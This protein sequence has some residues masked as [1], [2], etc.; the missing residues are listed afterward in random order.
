MKFSER[1]WEVFYGENNSWW[2]KIDTI[3]IPFLIIISVVVM[4]LE[5]TA[6]GRL[7]D[8]LEVINLSLA[9][10]FTIEYIYRLIA[11]KHSGTIRKYIFSFDG[12]IDILSLISFYIVVADP[13]I[14]IAL[15]RFLR[16][17]RIVRTLKF[18]QYSSE[19]KK[20]QD[21]LN[22]KRKELFVAIAFMMFMILLSSIVIFIV[23][24][25]AQPEKY[26]TL[27]DSFWWSVETLT[28]VGYGDVAPVTTLGKIL[29]M[30]IALFG[31]GIVAIPTGIISSGFVEYEKNQNDKYAQLHVIADLK[32]HGILTDE[33]FEAEKKLILSGNIF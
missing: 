22:A 28:T 25:V 3:I 7:S 20:V 21:I 16:L 18:L 23:E 13:S 10:L 4:I 19:F 17:L 6:T 29:T 14:N 2:T 5:V 11:N 12:V 9:T 26:R 1:V 27:F 15:L 30:F 33:E 32:Q 24:N 8:V 31:I